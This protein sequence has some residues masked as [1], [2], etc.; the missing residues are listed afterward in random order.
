MSDNFGFKVG[1]PDDASSPTM[2]KVG[3]TAKKNAVKHYKAIAPIV[4]DLDPQARPSKVLDFQWQ[5]MISL[6]AYAITLTDHL[7]SRMDWTWTIKGESVPHNMDV[8]FSQVREL[9]DL[10]KEDIDSRE[11]L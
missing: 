6:A 3:L 9:C 8:L 4:L 2:M 11:N 7:F 5:G 10:F 1:P